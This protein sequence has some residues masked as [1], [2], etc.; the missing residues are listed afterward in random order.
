MTLS[1]SAIL[2]FAR[3]WKEEFGEALTLDDARIKATH[4]LELCLLLL[5]PTPGESGYGSPPLT[6]L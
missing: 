1:E 6:T 5:Q 2:E 3:L 4:F